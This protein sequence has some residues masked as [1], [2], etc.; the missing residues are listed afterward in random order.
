MMSK[1]SKPS[2]WDMF[3]HSPTLRQIFEKVLP[4]RFYPK[5]KVCEHN[6]VDY[7]SLNKLAH[8]QMEVLEVLANQILHMEKEKE[9]IRK[10]ACKE[11]D[12]LK[13]ENVELK[14]RLEVMRHA[15]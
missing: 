11:L 14:S 5:P 6:R 15:H 7:K 1:K 12:K 2:L 8:K 9:V 13:A 10:A 4:T 3:K